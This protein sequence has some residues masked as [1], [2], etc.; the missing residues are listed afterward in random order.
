MIFDDY[1]APNEADA[2]KIAALADRAIT[3]KIVPKTGK[4][5]VIMD[6]TAAYL[7][8]KL[9]LDRLL[10]S[11]EVD[12]VHDVYGINKHLDSSTGKFCDCF[13]PRCQR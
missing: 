9:N 3:L 2:K 5:N 10:E 4:L 12:F 1:L 7:G 8:E 11:N 6:L 13:I